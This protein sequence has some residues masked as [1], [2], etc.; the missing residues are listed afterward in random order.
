MDEF[1][2]TISKNSFPYH[3]FVHKNISNPHKL[4]H[5]SLLLGVTGYFGNI[6][7]PV[8]LGVRVQ[9]FGLEI[10]FIQK[11]FTKIKLIWAK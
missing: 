9:Y 3:F 5:V 10:S 2:S 11:G 4:S 1:N 7:L 8:I 6:G